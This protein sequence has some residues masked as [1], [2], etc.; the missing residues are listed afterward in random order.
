MK[1]MGNVE[2][3][4]TVI[5]PA[6]LVVTAIAL[7]AI[8]KGYILYLLILTGIYMI[9][10]VTLSV[11]Y[12]QGGLISMA[13]AA[14]YGIGAYSAAI[15]EGRYHVPALASLPLS[16]AIPGLI[17]Y[18]MGR[19]LMRLRHL[20][21][22]VGTLAF[23]QIAM[24]FF[25]EPAGL[26]GGYTGQAVPP[27]KL[28]AFVISG[29]TLERYYYLTYFLLALVLYVS[30]ALVNSKIGRAVRAIR[31]NEPAAK[32]MGINPMEYKI[33]IFTFASGWAG[34]AGWL[35]GHYA[36]HISPPV[37]ATHFSILLL[38]MLFIGGL[39]SLWGAALGAVFLVFAPYYVGH[40]GA[41]EDLVYGVLIIIVLMFMPQGLV[42]IIRDSYRRTRLYL[43][44]SGS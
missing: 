6:L 32:A 16:F 36:G 25:N 38:L 27:I 35:Y 5:I 1:L 19:P 31:D 28:G 33:Y 14:F 26:T 42:G 24:V 34:V 13:H 3:K 29:H 30:I 21:L 43:R 11:L 23:S 17:A 18:L 37:F 10:T 40:F 9:L 15:V 4:R 22:G 12:G 44:E 2:A 20:Y 7:G 8:V 41:F 39:R